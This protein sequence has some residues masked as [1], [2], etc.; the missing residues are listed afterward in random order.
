MSVE[1][2]KDAGSTPR[3]AESRFVASSFLGQ[4]NLLGRQRLGRARKIEVEAKEA[5]WLVHYGEHGNA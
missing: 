4:T 5:R 2:K 1:N 3:L